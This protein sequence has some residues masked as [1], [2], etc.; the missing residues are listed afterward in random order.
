MEKKIRC[1]NCGAE[2]D[3]NSAKCPH[4]GAINEWGAE[5]EYIQNLKEI[6]EDLADIPEQIKEN[7]KKEMLTVWKK[8]GIVTG[9]SA[10]IIGVVSGIILTIYRGTEENY[11][12]DRKAK[13]LWA[14]EYYPKIDEWYEQGNYDAIL[15]LMHTHYDDEGYA[16]WD[17]EHYYFI[18][19]YENY[20]EF[21]N[22]V[23][24]MTNKETANKKT[25]QYMVG[26]VM[27]FL[28]FLKE[29]NYTTEEWELIQD[30]RGEIE[31]VLY[32]EM[33]FTEEEV[34]EL[35]EKVNNGGYIDYDECDKYT[36][37]IWKRFIK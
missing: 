18:A 11:E 31:E 29:M 4:C 12:V 6:K 21:M 9:V 19:A 16:V 7:Y 17:W 2:F 26:A 14:K 37:K 32:H 27:H 35:Y 8:I 5:K 3:Q 1:Q 28:F 20:L 15:E 24:Y 30:W 10:V 33:K 23:D 25:S 22:S 13:M 34:Q 36:S